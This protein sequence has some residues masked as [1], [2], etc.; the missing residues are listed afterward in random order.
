MWNDIANKLAALE[1]LAYGELKRRE[2]QGSAYDHLTRLGWTTPSSRKDTIRL[3]PECKTQ[4]EYMLSKVWPEW[5]KF[6]DELEQHALPITPTG[7]KKLV[8]RRRAEAIPPTSLELSKRTASALTA[9]HSKSTLTHERTLALEDVSILE[10]GLLRIIP[11]A[12]MRAIRGDDQIAFDDLI[13]VFGE[14]GLPQRAFS[15]GMKL[16]G[17]VSGIMFVEN[18]GAWRDM[19]HPRGWILVHVPG[20][21]TRGVA[22]FLSMF[23][24]TPT[25]HFGDLDPNGVR[26]F[27]HLHSRFS[28]VLWFVPEFW[29]EYIDDYS[30]PGAWPEDFVFPTATPSFVQGL[31]KQER[32]LEQERFALDPRLALTI[33]N[34]E[35][36]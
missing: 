19:E 17:S 22:E 3:R 20:W 8:D 29:S 33:S 21:D 31:A 13:P 24:N 34:L 1:L 2:I 36:M 4:L 12:G 28:Q 10:D 35:E 9:P 14:V 26:I 23:P 16:E 32:W 7:Y 6:L 25:Y 18:L 15:H 5:A 27:Q 30:I 11:P